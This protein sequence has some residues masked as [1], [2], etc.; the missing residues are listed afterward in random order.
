MYFYY[1]RSHHCAYKKEE[2][3]LK[4]DVPLLVNIQT[5]KTK[6]TKHIPQECTV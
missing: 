6:S 1:L 3:L 2:H 5:N 4:S